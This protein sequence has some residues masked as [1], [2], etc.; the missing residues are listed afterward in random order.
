MSKR[1]YFVGGTGTGVAYVGKERWA[2]FR[3][4]T[5]QSIDLTNQ[6]Q[7]VLGQN[8]MLIGKFFHTSRMDIT[9]TEQLFDLKYVQANVGSA[10][11]IGT[12]AQ[13]TETVILGEGGLGTVKGTPVPFTN[14]ADGVYGWADNPKTGETD[15]MVTFNEKNF[16]F[17]GGKEGDEVCVTYTQEYESG[18][19]IDIPAQFIPMTLHLVLQA[20]LYAA[21]GTEF[22]INQSTVVGKVIIDIPQ[23]V[24]NGNQTISMT[25][26]GISTSS[27]NGQAKANLSASCDDN[28]YYATMKIIYDSGEWYDNIQR[29]AVLPSGEATLKVDEEIKIDVWGVAQG[30][31][32]Y[33]P[34]ATDLTFDSN[35]P[36]KAT[37]DNNGTIRGVAEGSSV[38]TVTIKNKP[39]IK[40]TISVT[41]QSK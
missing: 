38:V 22:D 30:Y 40:S 15:V 41:V 16:T 3:A 39:S 21:F 5:E 23:Y 37:V 9:L 8:G 19:E 1:N 25:N 28:M 33:H 36:D 31:Q 6:V 2:R 35:T 26:T 7:E 12:T 24:L 29:L 20:N 34:Q 17:N 4:I 11:K 18:E 27:L 10:I 14:S 13:K 32:P